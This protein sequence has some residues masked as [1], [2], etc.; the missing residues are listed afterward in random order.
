MRPFV[1]RTNKNE[2]T[3][4]PG[5]TVARRLLG[6]DRR[7]P[8]ESWCRLPSAGS[9]VEETRIV[10]WGRTP[11]VSSQSPE[12]PSIVVHSPRRRSGHTLPHGEAEAIPTIGALESWHF[13]AMRVVVESMCAGIA[14]CG[15]ANADRIVSGN[16]AGTVASLY[17]HGWDSPYTYGAL[18]LVRRAVGASDRS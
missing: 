14:V 17:K 7:G 10:F 5:N 12:G 13:C 11:L 15:W 1:P 16:S 18:L 8:G 6:A 3:F 2:I 4:Y 9:V